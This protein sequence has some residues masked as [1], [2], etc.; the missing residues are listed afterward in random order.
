A[1]TAAQHAQAVALCRDLIDQGE[2]PAQALRALLRLHGLGVAQAA[3]VLSLLPRSDRRAALREALADAT[4]R[5]G[6]G[7]LQRLARL[8]EQDFPED[9]W[10]TSAALYASS[11][12][13]DATRETL[14]EAARHAYRALKLRS[15]LSPL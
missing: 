10:L 3:S 1:A 11:L 4:A 9:P 5:H 6:H 12:S 7:C 13:E 15:G 8:A 2:Q 14:A